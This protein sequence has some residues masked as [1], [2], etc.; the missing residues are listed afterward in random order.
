MWSVCAISAQGSLTERQGVFFCVNVC[1]L[2]R[3]VQGLNFALHS[4]QKNVRPKSNRR[5]EEKQTSHEAAPFTWNRAI[6]AV[7]QVIDNIEN[8]S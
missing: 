5:F 8:P 6:R 7:L 3:R 4:A 2:S 1:D